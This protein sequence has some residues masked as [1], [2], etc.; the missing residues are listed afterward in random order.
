MKILFVQKV[1]ALV[2]SE[3]YFLELIPELIKRGHE[4]EFACIYAQQD[5]ERTQAFIDAYSEIDSKLHLLEIKSEK[6]VLKAVRFIK[7]INKKGSFDLI[8]S[9][10]IHADFWCALLKKVYGIKTP[11]VSTKHGYEESY[12]ATHGFSADALKP[13][14]YYRLCKFSEKHITSS[15]AVSDGLHQLFVNSGICKS[16]NIQ[17][18]HHGFDLPKVERP[19]ESEYRKSEHQLV[20]L[21]RIIP[22]KGHQHLIN[23]MPQVAE[24]FPDVK[25]MVIGHGDEDLIA[26][27]KSSISTSQIEENVEFLGYQSNIYDHLV[28]SDVMIVPS[29]AEGFGLIFLEAL[30][31][32]LPIVGFDV[33]A[34]NEIIQNEK[35]GLLVTPYNEEELAM[36]IIELLQNDAKRNELGQ[37]GHQRLLQY[38]SLKRMV[39]QTE[40]FY[41]TAVSS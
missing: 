28:A 6:Q 23:A 15:F 41:Q 32:Q 31:A 25:L 4:I 3:K 13:N 26:S 22:F 11:I 21:G 1:K 27:L 40:A 33:P 5:L 17:T 14:L 36:K 9:H 10:L 39:D 38:F 37:A 34:T 8:H 35:T 18:I 30:N 19:A 7:D 16:E 20:V 2:G 12:I 29:I 24:A